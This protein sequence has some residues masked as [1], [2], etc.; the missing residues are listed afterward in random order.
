[1]RNTITI[2]KKFIIVKIISFLII[3]KYIYISLN[4]IKITYNNIYVDYPY[5]KNNLILN[6][7][8]Q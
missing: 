4:N 7:I 1:M 3:K 2:I 8:K 5:I 6:L